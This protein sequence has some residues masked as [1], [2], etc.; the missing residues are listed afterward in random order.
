MVI[1]ML[2]IL[3]S[4]M[5]IELIVIMIGT[6][7]FSGDFDS[8]F[9]HFGDFNSDFGNYWQKVSRPIKESVNAIYS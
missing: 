6:W 1:L 5:Y 4:V 8:N 3:M 2:L 7:H 9:N